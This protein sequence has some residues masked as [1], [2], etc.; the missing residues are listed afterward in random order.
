MALLQSNPQPPG[1][2]EHLYDVRLTLPQIGVLFGLVS[3]TFFFGALVLAFGLRIS[4]G[5]PAERLVAPGILWFGTLVLILSSWTLEAARRAL[6]RAL[7]VIYRGR[8]A[9]TLVL[10]ALFLGIQVWVAS[11]LI[12]QGIAVYGN[13]RG[14]AFYAFAGLHGAHPELCG[15]HPEPLGIDAG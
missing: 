11:E 13:P 12:G 10:A 14:A 2:S 9:A 8:V 15:A 5:P 4:T 7:V 1:R 6:R 3:L